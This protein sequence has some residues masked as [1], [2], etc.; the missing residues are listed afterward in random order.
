MRT[1][2]TANSKL[3]HNF[4]GNVTLSPQHHEVA[5][6]EADVLEIL[7]RHR[8]HR[9]RA[10]GSLHA[11]S[12]VAKCDDV[13][14]NVSQL[15]RVQL[16]IDSA[17]PSATVG[18][19]WQI[20]HLLAELDAQGWTT[21]TL[22]L[23]TEQT[24]SGAMATAT[25]GSGRHCLSHYVCNLRLATYDADGKPVVRVISGGDELRAACCSLGTM[26]IITEVTIPIRRQYLVEEHFREFNELENVIAAETEY[27]I[28]QFFLVPWKWS[29]LVQHRRET[30]ASRSWHAPL[31][32]VFWAW[33][34]DRG[35]HWW[36]IALARCL[37]NWVTP[38]S[39]R[40][41]L[42]KLV[43]RRWRVADRSD[44]QLTMQHHLYRHIETELFVKQPQ[45]AEML[46]LTRWLLQW[47]AGSE[48]PGCDAWTHA[49]GQCEMAS[50]FEKL[51]GSY[52]HHYPICIRK[53]KA[54]TGFITMSGSDD[55]EAWYAVSFISYA[56]PDKRSG[57]FQ[58][59]SAITHL[60][61]RLFSA[62]P[63]WGKHYPSSVRFKDLYP[64]FDEFMDVR[65]RTDPTD[66]FLPAWMESL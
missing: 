35:L 66:A 56:S 10:Y 6:S 5:C 31:Y 28:Q 11:W 58:F 2:A 41:V 48:Q 9:L 60:S 27:P 52:H 1:T 42:P 57:F 63:H 49:I 62:R 26:G 33:G 8:G 32:R 38:F 18:A 39:F 22:G 16:H 59:A 40:C 15:N 4:G 44:R 37:P 17:S 36:I 43:P 53:V 30:E 47:G 54:D 61:I 34:M 7:E 45:L 65:N 20:K 51:R 23:I 21:P 13:A 55:D 24:I 46:D 50:E 12:Q 29:F 19:G 14:V 64:H 25:H 3:I